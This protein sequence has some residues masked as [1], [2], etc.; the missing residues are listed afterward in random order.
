MRTNIVLDDALLAEAMRLT[1]ARTKK[2]VVHLALRELVSRHKQQ[3]LR[4]LKA[5]GLID[6]R[7]DVRSVRA[8]MSRDPR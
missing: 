6:E 5:R 1:G 2:E 8:R 3:M 7:Y 4:S